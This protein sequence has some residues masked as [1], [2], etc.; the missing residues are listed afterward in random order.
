M[1]L[2]SIEQ[3]QQEIL[4][5]LSALAISRTESVEDRIA[6]MEEKINA[7]VDRVESSMQTISAKFDA[8]VTFFGE[9]SIADNARIVEEIKLLREQLFAVSMVNVA[10]G[11]DER[12]DSY[13]NVILSELYALGDDL[14][15]L[16]AP[17]N[18]EEREQVSNADVLSEI[19]KL[20]RAISKYVP[21]DDVTKKT[22]TTKAKKE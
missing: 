16:L 22:K 20:K 17:N 10:E 5:A 15:T 19:R 9:S 18:N 7:T 11:E 21:I 1:R 2:D 13:H 4:A 6:S 12:Y 8:I 3:K 14:D